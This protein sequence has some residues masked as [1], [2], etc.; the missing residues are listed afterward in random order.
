MN[1]SCTVLKKRLLEDTICSLCNVIS[2]KI[3]EENCWTE[4]LLRRELVACILGSQ[5]RYET[6]I[7]ALDRIEQVGLLA[8]EWWYNNN[9]QFEIEI[10]KTLSCKTYPYQSGA[11]R[12]PKARANQIAKT[13]NTIA[14][15][16]F[17]KLFF[18][19]S[20]PKEIRR[21]L[22]LEISGLGPKQASMFLR[23]IGLSYDL[24]ILDTHVLNF[25]KM[26]NILSYNHLKISTLA[27]Y[28]RTENVVINYSKSLGYP[29][30]YLDWAIWATMKAVKEMNL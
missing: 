12:F 11:Y 5:V 15:R 25:L 10:Y 24:A 20:E 28:E 19:S 9:D 23:N 6:A 21:R 17:Y 22:V 3:L 13:R 26:Q 14:Q 18:E 30:G 29:V 16:S 4:Y 1:S 27:A 7:N 8:D 2:S